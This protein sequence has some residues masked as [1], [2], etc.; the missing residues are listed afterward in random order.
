MNVDPANRMVADSLEADW[1][2]CLRQ[3]DDLQQ[4]HERQRQNDRGLLGEE[5]RAR[6]RALA[7]DFRSVWNDERVESIE[8]KRMLG[9]ISKT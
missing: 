5:A 2:A 7:D 3:L 8:R 4:A 9:L 6:I 1:N